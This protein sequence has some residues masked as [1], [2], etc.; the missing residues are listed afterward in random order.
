MTDRTSL[1][2][3]LVSRPDG[4]P[5]PANFRV[6]ES[7]VREPG[8]GDVVVANRFISVDP[9]M[10]GRMRD[11]KSYVPPFQLNETM[12]GG[13]V[14]E[15]VESNS[16]DLP[17]GTNVVHGLG[18]RQYA[19]LPAAQ[20]QPVAEADVPLSANLGVLGMTGQ[21]AYVGLFTIA[22][23][24]EGD[25][26]FVSGAAG[27]VGSVVAQM[28]RNRGARAVIGSAGS[29]EKVA[30]LTEELGVDAAFNYR[31]GS[32]T[33]LL[34]D[35]APNGIDVYFDNVGGDHL[36]AAIHAL[37]PFG[38]V[39][40]CG[41]IAQYNATDPVPGPA[42]LMFA[43]GKR[44]R[45]QGF[46]VSDHND[47]RPAFLREAGQWLAE[48]KLRHDETVVEGIENAPQAFIDMLAGANTGKMVVSVSP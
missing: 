32:P 40:L 25:T 34:A 28:A 33:D 22:E 44:L 13:A 12:Q 26:V 15:V 42:N 2:V 9:Y 36:E 21:T 4:E 23:M 3:H 30:F 11:R 45:M 7:A 10:R 8:E 20:T 31:D 5:T 38:R 18:W 24:K 46:I 17:V 41:M 29:A 43:V 39:A 14:G 6:V 16:P 27:A 35:A 37:R 1:D 47:I 48:G 19:V